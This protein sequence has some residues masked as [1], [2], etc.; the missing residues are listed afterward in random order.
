MRGLT[1]PRLAGPV[2]LGPSEQMVYLH[3]VIRERAGERPTDLAG[4]RAGTVALWGALPDPAG[5]TRWPETVGGVACVRVATGAPRS[6]AVVVW[7]HGGAYTLGTAA[8]SAPA[9]G[10]L[11]AATGLPVVVVDYRLAPEHPFPAALEDTT[12]VYGAMLGGLPA[13]RIAVVGESAGGGL[14]LALLQRL[15]ETDRPLPA[16]A[17]LLAPWGD[18]TC[19]SPAWEHDEL[20][21]EA[22]LRAD[23]LA[24]AGG[25]D[26]RHPMLSPVHAELTGFPPLLLQAGAV[27]SVTPDVEWIHAN[28][29]AAGVPTVLQVWPHAPHPFQGLAAL[30]PEGALAMADVAS[31][32]DG[33]LGNPA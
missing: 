3:T 10:H 29:V 14:A 9:A 11:A 33:L 21:G 25:L 22:D 1:L 18:L 6:D 17:A 5:V 31:W 4:R 12:A 19:S 16:T 7:L 8:A 30:L 28:A 32:I 15:R 24:Y 26:L 2:D 20:H 27:D 23:A 13:T